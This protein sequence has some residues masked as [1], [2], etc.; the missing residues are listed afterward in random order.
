MRD[1][2]YGPRKKLSTLFRKTA[3]LSVSAPAKIRGAIQRNI[4]QHPLRK[5]ALWLPT[6]TDQL[7][8][9][10][11]CNHLSW[12]LGS[13]NKY[14]NNSPEVFILTPKFLC[15]RKPIVPD[16]QRNYLIRFPGFKI[17]EHGNCHLRDF[18]RIL[19]WR[20]KDIYSPNIFRYIHKTYFVDSWFYNANEVGSY[21]KLIR[22]TVD[23]GKK[24]VV[25]DL[26]RANFSRLISRWGGASTACVLGTGPSLIQ[27]K[28]HN[29]DGLPVIVCNSIVKNRELLKQLKPAVICFADPVFHFSPSEYAATFRDD[30]IEM[31]EKYDTFIFTRQDM[32]GLLLRHYPQLQN[33]LIGVDGKSTYWRTPTPGCLNVHITANIL[34]FLMIPAALTLSKRVLLAGNDGR[35]PEEN[36]FWKH[37]PTTQY[38]GLMQTAFNTHPS[39]FRDRSY[40]KYYATHCKLLEQQ[41]STFEKN[42]AEFINITKSHIPA[43]NR[44]T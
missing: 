30:L 32:I 18:D 43:L 12:Y 4:A 10:S 42:G 22:E 44:R 7:E 8:L 40:K 9:G 37:N 6:I 15:R 21:A 11:A 17:I 23:F 19:L 34:T 27:V 1:V 26:S 31:I 36:Y 39:F 16:A 25:N 14:S 24:D 20:A 3:Y 38:E 5:L 13:H 2:V 28:D 35:K 29:F 41:L 33:R